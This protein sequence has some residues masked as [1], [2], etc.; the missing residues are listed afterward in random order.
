MQYLL[1]IAIMPTRMH[2][3]D[4]KCMYPKIREVM[5]DELRHFLARHKHYFPA[6]PCTEIQGTMSFIENYDILTQG[7]F[8]AFAEITNI[9]SIMEWWLDEGWVTLFPVGQV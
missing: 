9:V 6:Q 7:L 8:Q 4:P 1:F 5:E 3:S 2:G